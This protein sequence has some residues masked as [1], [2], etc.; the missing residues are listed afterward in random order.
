M[1]APKILVVEDE[2]LTAMELQRKLRSW[3]YDVPTF[4]LSRKDAIKKADEIK[5]DLILMDIMLKGEGDGIDAAK[6]IL[7]KFDLPVIYLTGHEDK[8]ILERAMKSGAY[9]YLIKPFEENELHSTIERALYSHNIRKKL[10]ESGKW[11]E[12]SLKKSGKALIVADSDGQ[13]RFM[14]KNAEDFTGWRINETSSKDLIE[15]FNIKIDKKKVLNPLKELIMDINS[16]GIS[17]NAVLI[18]RDKKEIL[19]DYSATPIRNDKG[20]L[21]GIT[22][23]FQDVTKLKKAEKSLIVSEKRFKSIYSSAPIAIEMYDNDG[24]LILANKASLDL[25]GVSD[26]SELKKFNLFEDF[27]LEE[28][29]KNRLIKKETIK[30][31]IEFNFQTFKKTRSYKTTKSGIIYLEVIISP[32]SIEDESLNGYIVQF[33][34][35]TRHRV[36]EE[37]LVKGN[38]IQKGLLESIS[39]VFFA[40]D[41]DLKCIY[42]NKATETLTD[43]SSD[44]AVGKSL[45]EL[46]PEVKGK[47]VE[48]LYLRVLKTQEPKSI[49]K[50]FEL[51]GN[52]YFFK[53]EAYPSYYGVSVVVKDITDSKSTEEF[54]K[55]SEE[56]YKSVVEDQTDLIC[57]F[58]P[59]GTVTFVNE[60]YCNYFGKGAIG[61]SFMLFAPGE[62]QYKLKRFLKFFSRENPVK[63]IENSKTMP[64]GIQWWQW[65][66]KALFDQQG[67]ITEFQAVGRDITE[68]KRIEEILTKKNQELKTKI[69]DKSNELIKARETI[70]SEINKFKKLEKESES[71]IR[72]KDLLIDEIRNR[73]K[74]NMQMISSLTSLHSG[75]IQDQIMKKFRDSQN[76]IKSIALVYENLYQT[77]DLKS[78]DLSEFIKTLTDDL[79]RSY[80]TG[81]D[82]VKSIINIKNIILDIDTAITCGLIITELFTNSL[83]HAFPKGQKGNIKIEVISEDNGFKLI[84]ADNGIGLPKNIDVQNSETLGF[85]LINTL[86]MEINGKIKVDRSAGTK[87]IITFESPKIKEI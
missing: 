8:G 77:K 85:Q 36:M 50:K 5:P 43:V 32:L 58:T 79:L 63:V 66:N 82:S 53:I 17:K 44:D 80:G 59:D 41:K 46:F 2:G 39:D 47:R 81:K 64:D 87:F 69:K 49:V 1:S 56:L 3:G 19:I 28:K 72:D 62:D 76:Q 16:A 73:V 7:V 45:Y 71:S 11:F 70:K 23:I 18:A 55:K 33:H 74:Q 54:L 65:F 52:E 22:I 38:R 10:I 40:L 26:I 78:I 27:K 42:W 24:N 61:N 13:I 31:E 34:D 6:E 37:S 67:H 51:D 57:R 35:I 12:K 83:N 14:N 30:Y 84:V 75:Y 86:V 9:D 48:E 29:E 20:D 15:I 4:A 68:Y 60:A 21:V 25:F